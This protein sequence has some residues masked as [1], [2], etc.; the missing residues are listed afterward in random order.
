MRD[1]LN[2]LD[3]L[4]TEANLGAPEIPSAKLSAVPNPKTGRP[5]TRPE[6]FLVKVKTGSPFT[7]VSGGEV[8]IDPKEARA[9]AQWIA[10]GPKGPKGSITLRTQDGGT[11]KN[12]ELLKTVEFG[13]K[14]SE[15][16]KIKGSDVF[17][18]QEIDIQELGNSMNDV[19]AAG[20]FPASEMYSRIA[21]NPQ[22]KAM[23]KLGDA[24]IYLAQQADHAQVPTIPKDLTADQIKAIELYAS[25]YIGALGLVTGGVPFM[26]GSREDFEEFVGGNLSDM[27]MFFPKSVSNPLADS[28]SIVNNESGHAVKISS[29]AAGKG[30]APSLGSMKLPDDIRKKY[31]EA[32]KFIDVAQDPKSTAFSQPFDL[33]N[34]VASIGGDIPKEY[35]SMIPFSSNM[36]KVAQDSLTTNKPLPRGLMKNFEKRLSPK[37]QESATTDGGKIW[38]AVIQDLIKIVNEGSAIPNFKE[39]LIESLGYNFV[40]LYTNVRGDKLKTEAFWPAKISG[41]VKLKTKGS[42][43]EMKGKISV[44][45]SP[46]KT[47]F[48][49]PE[50]APGKSSKTKTSDQDSEEVVQRRSNIKAAG[51]PA[52]LGTEKSL[53]RK[54]QR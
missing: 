10:G 16:I 26:R 46:S 35:I 45:I 5:Y 19:L 4:L 41:Q 9:V 53:G 14:E 51:E 30:A 11:V 3:N 24:V 36:I 6:L 44:E 7:L 33:M 34:Y 28:F 43:G 8:V 50:I 13:S 52:R 39:A 42:A 23:G 49:E 22:L 2:L 31:P 38:W 15:N 40:Q 47:D 32:A 18:T 37:M 1:I 54:R 17:D 48:A 21:D 29:K 12:T 27:I 20:G 25:E